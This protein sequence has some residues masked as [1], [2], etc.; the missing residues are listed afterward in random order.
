MPATMHRPRKRSLECNEMIGGLKL[1]ELYDPSFVD[2][3][4]HEFHHSTRM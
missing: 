3:D 2:A 4:S 1:F